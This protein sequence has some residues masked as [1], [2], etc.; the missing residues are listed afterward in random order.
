MAPEDAALY[1]VSGATSPAM[2]PVP[3]A[4]GFWETERTIEH[5]VSEAIAAH[6]PGMPL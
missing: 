4:S 5:T 6:A 1:A 3:K 2:S